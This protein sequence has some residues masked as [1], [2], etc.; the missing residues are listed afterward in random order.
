MIFDPIIFMN[1][2]YFDIETYSPFTRPDPN[3]DKVITMQFQQVDKS[4]K[5]LSDLAILK[6]WESDEET[7]LRKFIA[8][9]KPWNFVPI[10]NNLNFERIFLKTKCQK[11]SISDLDKYGDL[12]YNF[13]SIDINAIFV[14]LNSGQFKGSG[15]HNFTKKKVDGSHIANWY[16]NREYEK[17]ET[18]IKEEAIAFL[19]FYQRC[20]VE[21]PRILQEIK[22]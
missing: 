19:D 7:I 12:A 11:Y 1:Y 14:I 9:F 20:Y 4:G 10:G 18:Y 13:P 2:Y 5:P 16:K 15:M 8:M 21:F 6:E 22:V 17:I 3:S